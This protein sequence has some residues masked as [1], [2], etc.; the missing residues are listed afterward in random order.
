VLFDALESRCDRWLVRHRDHANPLGNESPD[1]IL[2]MKALAEVTLERFLSTGVGRPGL[3]AYDELIFTVVNEPEFYRAPL[4]H[5]NRFFGYAFPMLYAQSKGRLDSE[6]REVLRRLVSRADLWA[7][8]RAPSDAMQ[9]WFFCE[10]S[11][12]DCRYD[13]DDIIRL[14]CLHHQPNVVTTTRI[15]AYRLTHD[16]FY[17]HALGLREVSTPYDVEELLTGLL[18]RFMIDGDYDVVLELLAAGALHGRVP[19]ELLTLG[20]AW[21][22]ETTEGMDYVPGHRDDAVTDGDQPF[23]TWS[24]S[25]HSTVVG[26]LCAKILREQWETLPSSPQLRGRASLLLQLGRA[27]H[28]LSAYRLFD[29]ATRL[30]EVAESVDL[31]ATY[32]KLASDVVSFIE[33]QRV[34]GHYGVWTDEQK[35]YESLGG[36]TD[37]FESELVEPVTVACRDAVGKIRA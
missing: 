12:Y 36:S 4:R 19:K 9:I 13:V 35:L 2:S 7:T 29:G 21:V 3:A 14:S 22:L 11:G 32:P 18:L 27:L 6:P 23:E 31:A 16:L 30:D 8:E 34:R 1:W 20:L 25:Y 5:P 24:S 28:D 10:L 17:Y 33:S 26:S 15:D 37:E